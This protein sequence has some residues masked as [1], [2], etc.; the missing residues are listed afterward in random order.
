MGCVAPGEEEEEKSHITLISFLNSPLCLT[1]HLKLEL[2]FYNTQS[3][4]CLEVNVEFQSSF[5]VRLHKDYFLYY[6]TN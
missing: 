3:D 1:S 6:L 4:S 2:P 5:P